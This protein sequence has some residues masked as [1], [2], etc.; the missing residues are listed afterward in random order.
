MRTLVGGDCAV[1]AYWD[2]SE[3]N[4][5]PIFTSR[6]GEG[7]V[8]A[9]IGLMDFNQSRRPESE[10]YSELIM[11]Q[12]AHDERIGNILSTIAFYVM[13]DGW[14]VAPGVI[15]E[16]MV[17]MYIPKTKLPHIMFVAPFQWENMAKVALTAKTIYPLVAVPISEAESQVARTNEGRDLEQLWVRQ[18]VDVLNWGRQSAA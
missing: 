2:E 12:R 18:A 8:A 16:R 1:T 7:T 11:D 10:I 15:F 3:E 14:K 13:K 17:E 4:R 5:A 6:N 9:T